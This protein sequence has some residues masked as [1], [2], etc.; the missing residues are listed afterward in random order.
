[1]KFRQDLYDQTKSIEYTAGF[2]RDAHFMVADK[3][4]QV[5]YWLGL[6]TVLVGVIGGGGSIISS[7][8]TAAGIAATTAG[9]LGAANSF[10]KPGDREEKHK[11]AGDDWS[12][13]RDRASDLYK[14]K[15]NIPQVQW[16]NFRKNTKIC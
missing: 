5:N 9:L 6:L 12:I 10:L 4:D 1:M 13:L 11:H 14:L 15:M 8:V 7:N 2:V 16:R 3:W